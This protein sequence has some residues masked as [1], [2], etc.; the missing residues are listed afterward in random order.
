M[1]FADTILRYRTRTVAVIAAAVCVGIVAMA[2]YLV[3]PSDTSGAEREVVIPAGS[4]ARAIAAIL[5]REDIIR[6]PLGFSLYAGI[7][8]RDDSLKAGRYVLCPCMSV[9][10][11]VGI[12]ASG[13]GLSDDIVVTVPEGMNIWDIDRLLTGQNLLGAV[14]GSFS[15]PY[16]AS[17]GRYFPDSYRLDKNATVADLADRMYGEFLER[18]SEYTDEQVIV[19]SMLEKEAKSADDMALVAGIIYRRMEIGMLLQIDATV[20]YG[21][22]LRRGTAQCDVTLAPIA[23]EI[24]VDGPYNSYIRAGLPPGPISNP[25]LKALEAAANP[26]DSEYLFYLSTRDGSE[27]IFSRTAEEHLENRRKHLGF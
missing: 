3:A 17:D 24:R 11:L 14:P 21:W 10:E 23:T 26:R 13:R 25:G 19:A 6:S 20:A 2:V 7:T 15:G 27:L 22:C 1:E 5:D 18:A 9:P 16:L 8:G 4:G 12:I